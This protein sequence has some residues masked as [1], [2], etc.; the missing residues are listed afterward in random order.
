MS[1]AE[2]HTKVLTNVWAHQVFKSLAYV[3]S[4]RVMNAQMQ[5]D[6]QRKLLNLKLLTNIRLF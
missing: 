4:M 6:S 2:R 5:T 3:D 1:G